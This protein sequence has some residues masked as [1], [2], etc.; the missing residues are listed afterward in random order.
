MTP[1]G[2][3]WAW[4]SHPIAWV[5]VAVLG[6]AYGL[7]LV[8]LGPVHAPPRPV[9][10]RKNL[11]SF[12]G[13]LLALALASTWPVDDLGRSWLL[14]AHMFDL[15]L[16]ALVAP[17]LLL[18]GLPRWLITLMT[19]SD[20]VDSVA[21]RLTRPVTA[22][23]I[24]NGVVIGS[25][26]PAVV[27]ASS[28]HQALATAVQAALVAAGVIMWTPVLKV[29]PGARH[30]STG[31]RIGY[32]FVQSLV[33]NFPALVYIFAQHPIYAPFAA[34]SHAVGLS[35][36]ADQQLA[37]AIAKIIGIGILWGTAAILIVRAQRAEEAGQDP[38]P[39]M[40]E[41]VEHELRQLERRSKRT[42]TGG[43]G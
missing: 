10:S 11:V 23:L 8:R 16:L 31:A 13:G 27:S 1:A 41:D 36:V 34:G 4:H 3:P 21:H 22:T 33:P 32:L 14:L 42:D 30:M 28:R 9:C 43:T 26:V 40:W 37:G 5:L 7:A 20:L 12:S 19:A 15:A 2:S 6:A 38:D 29:L 17:P 25:L 24:Y 35:A 39:L 18:L